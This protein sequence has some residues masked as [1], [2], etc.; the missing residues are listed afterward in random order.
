M[1]KY[2]VYNICLLSCIEWRLNG[3]VWKNYGLF[4]PL[5]FRPLDDSPPGS[6]AP[7]RGIIAIRRQK[8]YAYNLLFILFQ[9]FLFRLRLYKARCYSANRP[10]CVG[11]S[12]RGRTSQGRKSQGAKRLGGETAKGRKS[13]LPSG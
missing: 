3:V 12:A 1:V 8:L 11:E 9:G 4:A 13:Q 5:P 7:V 2:Y 10:R 6:F